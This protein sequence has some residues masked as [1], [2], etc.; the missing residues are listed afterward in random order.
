MMSALGLN[1]EVNE[2]LEAARI[3]TEI[4]QVVNLSVR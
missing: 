1:V 3:S 2:V 4:G